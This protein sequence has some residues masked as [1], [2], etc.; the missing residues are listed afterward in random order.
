MYC[1]YC[2]KEVDNDAVICPGC[3]KL[4]DKGSQVMKPVSALPVSNVQPK[5]QKKESLSKGTILAL[6]AFFCYAVGMMLNTIVTLIG[7]IDKLNVPGSTAGQV[8]VLIVSGIFSVLTIAFGIASFVISCIEKDSLYK[9]IFPLVMMI[10][11]IW[12]L[13]YF[14]CA[15]SLLFI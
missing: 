5:A 4:T 6:T 12:Y 13:I 11:G 9:R 7:V 10:V 14:I 1:K 15:F 2:G 3:G 8:G